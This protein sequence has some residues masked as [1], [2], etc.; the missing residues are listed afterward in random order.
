[1]VREKISTQERKSAFRLEVPE[2]EGKRR[3][4]VVKI[5]PKS[6]LSFLT[7]DS[8][9]CRDQTR[10]S[11]FLV[12]VL[13]LHRAGAYKRSYGKRHRRSLIHEERRP[14]FRSRYSL[15]GSNPDRYRH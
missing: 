8:A 11:E 6:P 13:S 12:A 7:R 4:T 10:P 2:A 14:W 3:D 9:R 1:M 5:S 15:S